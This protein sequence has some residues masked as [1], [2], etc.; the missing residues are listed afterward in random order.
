MKNQ[1]LDVQ[2]TH[3]ML[4][5]EALVAKPIPPDLTVALEQAFTCY[6][7]YRKYEFPNQ[8]LNMNGLS[9]RIYYSEF[10]LILEFPN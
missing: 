1:N 7:N 4:H 8:K 2:I 3:C 5:R 6:R 10:I 9:N